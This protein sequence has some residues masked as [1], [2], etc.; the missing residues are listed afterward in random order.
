[1]RPRSLS[2]GSS[3]SCG[4][5]CRIRGRRRGRRPSVSSVLFLFARPQ[6]VSAPVL[7][8]G[9]RALPLRLPC[10][11]SARP[12]FRHQQRGLRWCH[13]GRAVALLL[14]SLVGILVS[15]FV[16]S[17][18]GAHSAGSALFGLRVLGAGFVSAPRALL[19]VLLGRRIGSGIVRGLAGAPPIHPVRGAPCF[20][21]CHLVVLVAALHLAVEFAGSGRLLR[22]RSVRP[23]SR[24]PGIR[25]LPLRAI[26][27][28]SGGPNFRPSAL[29]RLAVRRFRLPCFELAPHSSVFCARDS[30]GVSYAALGLV[31]SVSCAG[32]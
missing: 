14:A 16:L 26:L 25:V 28:S 13:R 22:V 18:R 12:S 17:R 11:G 2:S 3:R 27:P 1:M 7:L 24:D 30:G 21:G 20:E 23:P 19:F 5:S 29:P 8:V 32:F 6:A 9:S 4:L 31:L 10:F 15:V